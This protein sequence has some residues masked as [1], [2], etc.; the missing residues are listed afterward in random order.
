MQVEVLFFGRPRELAGTSRETI[1]AGPNLRLADV[2]GMLG[3][4]YGEALAGELS[5]AERLIVFVNGRDYRTVGGLDVRLSDSDQVAIL[6]V[7][8]GG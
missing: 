1:S 5:H 8:T 3:E 4:K 7:V 6:P 2:F